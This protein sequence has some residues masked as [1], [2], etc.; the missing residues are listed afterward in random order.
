MRTSEQGVVVYEGPSLIDG[1]D[2]VAVATGLVRP[3][4]NTKTGPMVQVWFLLRSVHPVDGS[5]SGEDYGICGQCPLRGAG[6]GALR[7]CYVRLD[8]A[9]RVV[10]ENYRDGKYPVVSLHEAE[11]IM[12]HREVRIGAYGEPTAAPIEVSWALTKRAR[13]WTG[14]TH[15]WDELSRSGRA[16][17]W[18]DLLM[19]SVER[20][21][22]SERAKRLGWR[23]FLALPDDEPLP[24][25]SFLCPAERE[26]NPLPCIRCG[27][28]SGTKKRTVSPY[29]AHPALRM[30]GPGRKNYLRLVGG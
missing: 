16:G 25:G 28:C 17:R 30:H 6:D 21:D 12:A 7:T 9:P 15:R 22:D 13:M 1:S 4:E 24:E 29:A 23:P 20:R 18:P 8:A 2:I 10:W 19:A 14:Y 5:H 26:D 3:S 27:A 11:K